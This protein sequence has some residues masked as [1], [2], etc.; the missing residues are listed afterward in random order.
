[1][2]CMQRIISRTSGLENGSSID[3]TYVHENGQNN[4]GDPLYVSTKGA[5][6]QNKRNQ[7]G[8]NNPPLT[9]NGRPLAFDERRKGNVCGACNTAG[10]NRRN[11]KLCRLHP[12]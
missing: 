11:A 3:V 1:M 9:K 4:I 6:K 10:H 8:D 7:D 2:E 12:E 5:P